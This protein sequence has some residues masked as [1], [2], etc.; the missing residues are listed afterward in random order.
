MHDRGVPQDGPKMTWWRRHGNGSDDVSLGDRLRA[1]LLKP[2]EPSEQP[3]P[4][5]RTLEE[6]RAAERYADDKERLIGLVVAPLA[7]AVSLFIANYLIAHD[8]AA[9]LRNGQVNPL[10]ASVA[11]YHVLEL[12]LLGLSLGMLAAAWYR[13]RLLMGMAMAL[14]GLGVFNLHYWGFGVPFLVVGSWYLVRAYRA[15]QAVR[16]AA[17]PGGT[18][19]AARPKANK[20]YTPPA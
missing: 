5:T 12:V 15:H 18:S 10:H 9:Y 7:A 2:A 8:P 13:R 3:E 14:F 19:G 17:G 4:D 6:L 20:R 1:A 11:T 16:A